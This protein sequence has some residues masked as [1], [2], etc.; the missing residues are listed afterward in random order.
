[1]TALDSRRVRVTALAG[2]VGGA[3]LLVGLQ[4]VLPPGS[5]TA[6]V[7]TG[8]DATIYGIHVSPDVDIVTYWLAGIADTERGW[9]IA[10]DTFAMLE[11]RA[12][13]GGDAWFR[14]GDRDLATCLYR[15]E[16]LR[17]GETLSSVTDRIRRALGVSTPIVPM[18]D[19]AVRTLVECADGRVLGFQDYF[20][21]EATEPEVVAVAFDGAA[22]AAPAPDALDAIARAGRIVLCP[23][24]P[25]LSI[26]PILE[27]P[28]IRDALRAHPDVV[29]VTPIVAGRALKGP[30]DRL[31]RAL[32]G[33]SSAAAVARLY[34][35]FCDTFVVDVEDSAQERAVT[36]AGP[37]AAA[38]NT[39][40]GD[41][42][43]SARL[44]AQLVA[45]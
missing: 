18:S 45:L 39:I 13:L 36:A 44:A 41:R 9:G 1:M 17:A 4:R 31:L 22:R 8:D 15:T 42:D 27:L 16:R 10:G 43:A 7:N 2:G 24:N 6:I 25:V 26:G 38:L 5:L 19:D 29:A 11:A 34:A 21:K 3:K 28:G 12:R 14:L 35:D 23:S 37:R 20:V 40:M 33:D 32:H 30:A